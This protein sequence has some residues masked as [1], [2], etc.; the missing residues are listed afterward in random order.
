MSV[1][2][3]RGF[4]HIV[5]MNKYTYEIFEYLYECED[6]YKINFKIL[7]FSED[8]TLQYLEVYA[9]NTKYTF[10]VAV[11]K[12]LIKSNINS[13]LLYERLTDVVGN[14]NV[15]IFYSDE[16]DKSNYKCRR[17]INKILFLNKDYLKIGTHT[18]EIKYIDQKRIAKFLDD[19]CFDNIFSNHINTV[20]S[21]GYFIDGDLC[22]VLGLRNTRKINTFDITHYGEYYDMRLDNAFIDMINFF[23]KDYYKNTKCNC[24]FNMVV[25][26]RLNLIGKNKKYFKKELF[27]TLTTKL[28]NYF[29]YWANE[30]ERKMKS[31]F[32][33]NNL[34]KKYENYEYFKSS[35]EMA[36]ELGY[37]KLKLF[38]PNCYKIE[39]YDLYGK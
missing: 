12:E 22:A 24:N 14:Y 29:Y 11:L 19:Y 3:T 18:V 36:N 23:N 32:T 6:I 39:G 30:N 25:D 34:R 17:F 1:I 2:S 21:I 27:Y 5:P 37:Y 33:R 9:N 35:E 28:E 15:Y 7:E 20:L 10:A 4:N 13:N 38:S 26:N 16:W 8:Y 31:N